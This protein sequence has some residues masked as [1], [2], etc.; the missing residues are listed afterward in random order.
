MLTILSIVIII[1]DDETEQEK[2]S[3][4]EERQRKRLRSNAIMKDL[5]D[6]YSEGPE[7]IRVSVI[8]LPIC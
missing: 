5:R 6:Q 7:E 1:D 8:Y 3:K 2:R 4:L